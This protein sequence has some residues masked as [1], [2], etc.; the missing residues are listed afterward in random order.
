[1]ILDVE[2]FLLNER[3]A[4]EELAAMLR[5]FELSPEKQSSAEELE[6]FHYLYQ[7]AISSLARLSATGGD[8]E[9]RRS[10]EALVA[11]AYGE[12][13]QGRDRHSRFRFLAWLTAGFPQAFRRHMTAFLLSV[14][15]TIAGT[16]FGGAALVTIQ[17]AKPAL[18][19]FTQLNERPSERVKREESPAG[20]RSLAGHKAEFAAQL[21]T[22]N[23]QVALMTLAMGVTWGFGV[24]VLL[25]Y[26]GVTLGA[27]AVDYVRD[28]QLV[29]LLG[30]LMP[31]GVI[32]IPAILVGG[33]AGLVLATALAGFGARQSRRARLLAARADLTSLAGGLAV[34][35]VWAGVMEAFI[36]QYHYPTLPYAAKILLG[37]LELALLTLWLG[38]GGRNRT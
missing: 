1:M 37:V 19:P 8:S 6:R 20:G 35:L 2:R 12:I 30:W 14:A 34:M 23:I 28:G 33:Q 25:F 4:W 10:V 26:N 27:V 13:H 38:A 11:R 9:L 15:I 7:R 36:S 32:E 31:H 3:P 22:H 5:R 16:V 29:F 18:M 17:D 21:M 24:V